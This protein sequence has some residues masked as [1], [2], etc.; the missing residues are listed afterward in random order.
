MLEDAVGVSHRHHGYQAVGE[1]RAMSV[2]LNGKNL[3]VALITR[4]EM[5]AVP[6]VIGDIRQA[7]RD[8]E[9]LVVDSSTDS[10]AEVARELGARVIK[11]FPPRGYGPA[12]DLALRSAGGQVVVTLDCDDTYP[13]EQIPHL[14]RLVL[15]DGYDIVDGSRL[16]SKPR[17]MPWVNYLGNFV[18]ALIA[19]LLFLR[20]VRDLHSGMRAYRKSL[21]DELEYRADGAA[22]PVELLLRPI[23]MRKCLRIVNIEYR[24]RIGQTKMRSLQ[25]SWWTL[26]RILTVRFS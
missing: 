14:A 5:G 8:A 20:R 26:R 25:T 6:K 2:A 13:A 7:V 17:A 12:M 15:E 11:Q 9:I 24:E 16:A 23:K 18:F 19:S 1:N 3:T 4:N 10:T 22:L 21:I